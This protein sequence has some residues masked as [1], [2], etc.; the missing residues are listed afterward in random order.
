MDRETFDKF[1]TRYQKE[2]SNIEAQL[3][4]CSVTI[5][6]ISECIKNAVDL[7]AKLNTVW[8]SSGIGLKEELQKLIFPQGISYDRKNE[9]FRTEEMNFIFALIEA[10]SGDSEDNK[11]R[12]AALIERLSHSAEREGGIIYRPPGRLNDPKW[13][14]PDQ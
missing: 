11:K 4:E 5:S 9:A 8:A 1:N 3:T 14:R 12:T 6:N 7:S 10:N 2:R 13:G